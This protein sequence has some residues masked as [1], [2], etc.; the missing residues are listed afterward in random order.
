MRR[1]LAQLP[2]HTGAAPAYLFQR[3]WRLAGA[4]TMAVVDEYGP[5]EM[6]RRLSDP[7]WFQ[8]FGCVLGFDWH[9][10]GVTTVTC[11]AMKEAY[12]H[13]GDD[14][15]IHVAGGKGATSRKTP[16]E[17][18][19]ISHRL[20][21]TGGNDLIFASK[22]SAKVDSAAVQ[23]GFGLY[24]HSF[25]FTPAGQWCV[26]QQ[27]MSDASKCARRYHWLGESLNDFVIEPH[28]AIDD[29]HSSSA[30]PLDRLDP[31]ASLDARSAAAPRSAGPADRATGAP[32]A[33]LLLNMV[34]CEADA[35]RKGSVDLVGWN[36]DKL[37]FELR[38]RAEGPTLFAPAHHEVL[39]SD[40][41]IDRL[42][43]VIR[44]A[45]EQQPSDFA[46]LLG[47]KGVGPATVRALSLLAELIYDAPA[48]HR[49]PI[50]APP[51][52]SAT[53]QPPTSTTST[54][55]PQSTTTATTPP[56]GGP[57]AA[58]PP[59]LK[60]RAWAD[61][62]YAHGGKD[63]TPHPV[64]RPTYDTSIA[65]LTDAVRKSRV[66]DTEKTDALRRLATLT[67]SGTVTD[68]GK[69]SRSTSW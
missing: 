8:A 67:R 45:H 35:N 48:S 4:I 27:G 12:K 33:Q 14:L 62:S 56:T 32:G 40:V 44:A 55:A 28:H 34:A 7:W 22:M 37:I 10:S 36:P 18:G 47:A 25:F 68:E 2:L 66:G 3:M 21:I 65:V 6:L 15:G 51:S 46:A 63:G 1:Q 50:H 5:A 61:Y 16:G 11:G 43:P 9:S 58:L 57:P 23:D 30:E 59:V 53:S 20:A 42:E 13:F 41:N 26:V 54:R 38:R 24:H 69:R 31:L 52:Q 19:T 49:D 39:P 17:I 29:L 60:D 64:D